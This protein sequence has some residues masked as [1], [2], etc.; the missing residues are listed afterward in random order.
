MHR[1]NLETEFALR[2]R[3][4]CFPSTLRWR[5]FKTKQSPV[6]LDVNVFEKCFPST[7]KRKA[8][9]FK[10]LW[11]EERFRKAPFSCRFSVDGMPNRTTKALF[12][13]S[14]VVVWNMP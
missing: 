11:F 12:S 10:F 8:D 14:S 5:N 2:K 1:R 7:L 13:N 3:I 6:I 9:V 4:K